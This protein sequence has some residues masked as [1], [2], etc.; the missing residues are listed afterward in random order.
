MI[1]WKQGI[2]GQK[3]DNLPQLF[4]VLPSFPHAVDIPGELPGLQDSLHFFQ[5]LNIA[6]N[7]SNP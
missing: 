1:R 2:F 5:P 6:S 7:D 4:Q 3:L